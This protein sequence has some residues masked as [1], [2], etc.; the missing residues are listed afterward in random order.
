MAGR[1]RYVQVGLGG[2]SGMYSFALAGKFRECGELVAVCD[3]NRGRV[4]LRVAELAERGVTAQGYLADR[5]ERMIRETKAD[6]VIVTTKDSHHD[7][8]LCKAMELGCD[9]ITEKPLTTDEVKCQRIVDTQR[10][11]GRKCTVTF[12]YRYSPPRTQVKDL[13]MSGVIGNVIAVDF[14]W[15]L[16]TS[17]G[18]DYFRRWHRNTE[19]SGSL[20]VHKA[21][22]HFD[23]VNWFLSAIPERVFAMGQRAYY[24][25][26]TADRYGLTRRAER[27]LDCPEASKC[28][29]HLDLR[30]N[31]GLRTLYLD[32]E[33][34]D[35]YQRDRCVFSEQIDIWDSMHVQV[36]YDT[37]VQMSYSLHAFSP[38]EGYAIHFTGTKGRLEH[39][40]HE[41]VYINGD[42][43]VPG[44]T[45]PE[46]TKT[47]IFPHWQSPYSVDIWQAS[48]GHG[49]GD[50][51]LL[52]AVFDPNAPPD[53]YLRAADQRA[54]AYSILTGIAARKS[55]Q[56]GRPVEIA[57]LCHD[58]GRPDY[59]P[60]PT[61]AEPLPMVVGKAKLMGTEQAQK[62]R[63]GQAKP[64][65]AAGG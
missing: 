45:I 18:A 30:A 11:T 46:G 20:L 52:E 34:H 60:M 63:A 50:D 21:T 2:R 10:K 33:K 31:K 13:L 62:F 37:G 43:S 6:V 17:H 56:T 9:A 36:A 8:Y 12:N 41:S 61:S 4:D 32:Q 64:V 58:I 65:T 1:K 16:D 25:P 3:S 7:E 22:H 19:H 48:G 5:F 23:G 29:F 47:T 59:P 55:I 35:G 54:G 15:L 39:V 26:K 53:K 38:W 28:A 49:G 24:T 40:C 57:D 14:H 42:G 27:C 44:E 51:P